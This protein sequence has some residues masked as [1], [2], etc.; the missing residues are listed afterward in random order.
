MS[1]VKP[2]P[3]NEFG[4]MLRTLVEMSS[5]VDRFSRHLVAQDVSDVWHWAWE[6]PETVAV[7]L[8]SPVARNDLGEW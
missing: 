8:G 3:P 6:H 2:R 7:F 1:D 4:V 5:P